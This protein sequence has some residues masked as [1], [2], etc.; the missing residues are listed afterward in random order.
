MGEGAVAVPANGRNLFAPGDAGAVGQ[1]VGLTAA[2]DGLLALLDKFAAVLLGVLACIRSSL[3]DSGILAD[4]Q[5]AAGNAGQRAFERR[6][7]LLLLFP[8]ATVAASG[9]RTRQTS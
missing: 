2:T 9:P 4:A 3:I 6:Q 7:R 1:T 8:R 5:T